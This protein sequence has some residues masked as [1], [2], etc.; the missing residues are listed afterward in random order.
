MVK[1]WASIRGLTCRDDDNDEQDNDAHNQT[2]AHLHILPPH[3][4]SDPVGSTSKALGGNCQIIGLILQ[5]VK[6]LAS[7]VDLVDVFTHDTDGIIDL[8]KERGVSRLNGSNL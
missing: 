3:L 5:R 2:H 7:L 8:L 4:L 6:L 1:I